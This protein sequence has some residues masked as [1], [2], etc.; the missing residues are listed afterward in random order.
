MTTTLEQLSHDMAAAV[1][2]AG[3][4]LV[5]IEGRRRQAATGIIWRADGLIVTANHVVEYDEG[6]RVTLPGG[7]H[8]L[9]SVV[10]RDGTT[11]IALLRVPD[12][13]LSA[14]AWA[15][16]EAVAVGQIVMAVGR[17]EGRLQATLG[18]VSGVEGEWRTSAGGLIDQ[19]IQ[20][21]V[22]MYPGF[23]GGPL[24]AASGQFIGMNSSALV[25][26]ASVTL[27]A[28]TVARAAA[29]LAAHGRVRR[30]YLGVSAHA[31]RLP[32]AAAEMLGQE[33]GL[34][35]ASVEAGSPAEA[36]GMMLGDV[37][38]MLDDAPIR[39]MDDLM[40]AL[41]SEHIGQPTAARVLRGGSP[42]MLTVTFTERA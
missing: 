38:V 21:D 31:V 20:T 35:V 41:S 34:L 1:A 18:I 23:S 10:G 32:A 37:L 8:A 42:H 17:P 15:S 36:G 5:R 11:D 13:G 29:M 2:S 24:L 30:G 16:A 4:S 27:P 26:G 12:S 19:Y 14:A 25:R 6:I 39:H 40:L 28:A 9:A 33:T 22:V 3:A 7:A